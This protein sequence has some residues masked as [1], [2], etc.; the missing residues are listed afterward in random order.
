VSQILR[1][2][3]L[4]GKSQNFIHEESKSWLKEGLISEVGAHTQGTRW[5]KYWTDLNLTSGSKL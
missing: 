1:T 5:G 2:T 3:E 4:E